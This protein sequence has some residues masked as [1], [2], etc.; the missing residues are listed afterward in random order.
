[1]VRESKKAETRKENLIIASRGN[2]DRWTIDTVP[3]R[4]NH[5]DISAGAF[6]KVNC[7]PKKRTIDPI[8]R[9]TVCVS[10]R[11]FRLSL[12]S[13]SRS[14]TDKMYVQIKCGKCGNKFSVRIRFA[15]LQRQTHQSLL[16]FVSVFRSRID[17]PIFLYMYICFF[18]LCHLTINADEWMWATDG[19][20]CFDHL[21]MSYFWST[22][23]HSIRKPKRSKY[24]LCFVRR[25]GQSQ[26]TRN[27][28]TRVGWLLELA[29]CWWTSHNGNHLFHSRAN[30]VECEEQKELEKWASRLPRAH[31]MYLSMHESNVNACK[32][33]Q[34]TNLIVSRT[35]NN[36]KTTNLREIFS[37]VFNCVRPKSN[38]GSINFEFTLHCK[39]ILCSSG[40]LRM[41]LFFAS[42]VDSI[43]AD[44]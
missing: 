37:N 32:R 9:Y 21:L 11:P 44:A 12:T 24:L 33:L 40:H 15:L 30:W 3:A 23:P 26:C 20:L 16:L 14:K 27:G 4:K 25:F 38:I 6:T 43:S 31:R 35:L 22:R 1:M 17:L 8:Y 13:R 7:V 36:F 34:R 18:R 29:R 5:A 19:R 41:V 10:V 2:F 39:L 42:F 28:R